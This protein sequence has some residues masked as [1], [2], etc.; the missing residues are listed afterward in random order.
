[1]THPT[2]NITVPTFNQT[3]P[4]FNVTLPDLNTTVP[5]FT[6]PIVNFTMPDLNVTIPTVNVTIPD[7]NFT[8]PN[9]TG[10]ARCPTLW[11]AAF[12]AGAVKLSA[13]IVLDMSVV[14]PS[15]TVMS[16]A[17]LIFAN[18]D[19][20][21][22]TNWIHVQAGGSLIIGTAECPYTARAN[23]TLLGANT[24]RDD[25][26]GAMGT[27][28]I[29]F[30]QGSYL[31]LYGVAPLPTWTHLAE[32]AEAGAMNITLMAAV[33]WRVGQTIIIASTGFD[34][35]QTEERTIVGLSDDGTILML[36]APLAWTH[37]GE[38]FEQA[39]VAVLNRNIVI[40]GDWQSDDVKFGG[41]FMMKGPVRATIHAVEFT[42]LGQ[43]GRLGRYPLHFHMEKDISSYENVISDNSIHHNYQRCIVVHDTRGL[44]IRDNVA[45]DTEGHCYFLEDG[46]EMNNVL[47]HNLG[48][49]VREGKLL[50]SDSFPA[51]Y[52]ITNANN[53][54]IENTAVGGHYGYW[55]AL[56]EHPTGASAPDWATSTT[57]WPRQIPVQVFENNIAHSASQKC[58]FIDK[59]PSASGVP[60]SSVDL[61]GRTPP[62]SD[63]PRSDYIVSNFSGLILYKCRDQSIWTRG[64]GH[65]FS[66][67]TLAD[68]AIGVQMIGADLVIE[69]SSYIQETENVE[70]IQ[71]GATE[72]SQA[73][74]DDDDPVNLIHLPVLSRGVANSNLLFCFLTTVLLISLYM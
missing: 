70:T 36:D 22:Q 40:Q 43:H 18:K 14:V 17:A 56:P 51:V 28:G 15:I 54:F 6:V 44:I 27:K 67:C 12:L 66:N 69:D 3:V 5:N 50:P 2:T 7:T 37:W 41:H 64:W 65:H 73:D 57:M 72:A 47:T 19:L 39:E 68:F 21:L 9:T 26:G 24:T 1:V 35:N 60:E 31:S 55:F 53:T 45:Y 58:L 11:S 16:G 34:Q 4:V 52:W 30:D 8:R 42:R 48:V 63:E 20:T 74:S 62:Y 46:S 25:I 10:C 49:Y 32:T 71:K 13:P 23:I 38:G 33:N 29:A 61:I 59:G